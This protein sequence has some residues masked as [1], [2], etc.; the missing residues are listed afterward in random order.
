MAV[1]QRLEGLRNGEAVSPDVIRP[2]TDRRRLDLDFRRFLG[3]PPSR[4]NADA[5]DEGVQLV[6]RRHSA[7][8]AYKNLQNTNSFFL[9]FKFY[10]HC[11]ML[12]SLA[13]VKIFIFVPSSYH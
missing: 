5:A 6:Q 1:D 7:N 12:Y 8:L 9:R 13:Q 2:L 3:Q 10:S 4:H 11:Q